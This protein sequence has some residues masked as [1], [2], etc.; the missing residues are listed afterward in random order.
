M[1]NKTTKQKPRKK[2]GLLEKLGLLGPMEIYEYEGEVLH[3]K[4]YLNESGNFKETEFIFYLSKKD[5]KSDERIFLPVDV[6][7]IFYGGITFF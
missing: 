1:K 2:K 5:L 6:T 7:G 4:K 3:L